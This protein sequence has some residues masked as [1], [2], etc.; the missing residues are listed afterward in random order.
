M[1]A[2]ATRRDTILSLMTCDPM[3]GR[4]LLP[5]SKLLVNRPLAG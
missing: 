2:S 4:W 1:N 5:A 3:T